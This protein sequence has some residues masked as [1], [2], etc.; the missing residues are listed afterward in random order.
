MPETVRNEF[1]QG[2][3]VKGREGYR[4]IPRSK[5]ALT[6]TLSFDHEHCSCSSSPL[7]RHPFSIF[8]WPPL[9]PPAPSQATHLPSSD[10]HT[11]SH[12]L[13]PSLPPP[14]RT[15]R[16]RSTMR[17][18]D[19]VHRGER[20]TSS[21]SRG[22]FVLSHRGAWVFD[23]VGEQTSLPQEA[24]ERFGGSIPPLGRAAAQN[25]SSQGE[26]ALHYWVGLLF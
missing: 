18:Q 8:S 4:D 12:Q 16:S 11:F 5:V 17:C 14:C 24:G 15:T 2:L 23:F 9:P 10:N 21:T 7:R 25:T 6:E 19:L 1:K 3:R 20:L 22:A 26:E 13:Q